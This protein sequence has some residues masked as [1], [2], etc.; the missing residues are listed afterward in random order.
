MRREEPRGNPTMTVEMTAA[1]ITVVGV[2]RDGRIDRGGSVTRVDDPDG[3]RS[4]RW[5]GQTA[6]RNEL[7]ISPVYTGPNEAKCLLETL[8]ELDHELREGWTGTPPGRG[9]RHSPTDGPAESHRTAIAT[10]NT[11]HGR[12]APGLHPD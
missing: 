9:E 5:Q 7:G 12:S 4:T 6:R 8:K 2:F 11:T 1:G 3:S 10:D